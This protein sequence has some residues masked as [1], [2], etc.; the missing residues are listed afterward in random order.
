MFDDRHAG[1]AEHLGQ[2]I[3]GY[4]EKRRTRAFAGYRLRIRL[5]R[6]V[7]KVT[8]PSTF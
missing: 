6:A 1:D 4:L 8:L 7:W 2:L 5:E 3:R